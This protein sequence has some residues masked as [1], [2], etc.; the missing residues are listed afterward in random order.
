M[1]CLVNTS[2][3]LWGG[4]HKDPETKNGCERRQRFS[5][6]GQ[7][8][9]TLTP[10]T[11]TQSLRESPTGLER[12]NVVKYSGGACSD[13]NI[14]FFIGFSVV[15]FFVSAVSA[16]QLHVD[17]GECTIQLRFEKT[18]PAS[19]ANSD[20]SDS[21][22]QEEE[23]EDEDG[24]SCAT[25]SRRFEKTEPASLWCSCTQC[26]DA[27]LVSARKFR[28]CMEVDCARGKLTF[29]GSIEQISCITQHADYLALINSTILRQVA[30]LLQDRNGKMYCC[31]NGTS[32]NKYLPAWLGIN[33]FNA[34]YPPII[35]GFSLIICFWAETFHVVGLR[36]D[37]PRFLSKSSLAF[38]TFNVF[39]FLVFLAQF[40]TIEITDEQRKV[41]LSNIFTGIFVVLMFLMLTLF[42]IYGVE[43]YYKVRGAFTTTESSNVDITQAAM[44]R[45]GLF[46]QASLQLLTSLFLLGDIMGGKWKHKLPMEGR[47]ALEVVF[48]VFELGV[49][50]WFSCCLWN[51]KS[52]SQ[53]WILN[54]KRLLLH[55]T[56]EET[57]HLFGR[58]HHYHHSYDAIETDAD[59]D[60]PHR[61]CWIC[62][63]SDRTDAGPMILPCNC[64]GDVAAV[65]H[66]C[67][68]RWL[69]ETIVN[70]PN[71]WL[72]SRWLLGFNMLLV[73]RRARLATMSIIGDPVTG[74]QLPGESHTTAEAVDITTA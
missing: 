6:P 30:P 67:L 70:G 53:L 29:D 13:T 49:A 8:V 21:N 66:D 23:D 57:S 14:G 34:Y 10:P 60:A 63:D 46:S 41:Y 19:L 5:L 38:I 1:E 11:R 42:L 35:S 2:S 36:L 12:K 7:F 31:R 32:E 50:L 68:K 16:T 58:S 28:C 39:L 52:P 69:L 65:H 24:L 47:N 43:L 48:R 25:L 9:V 74:S 62:Y 71:L 72:N 33:L 61:D 26:S 3:R 18:E 45:F 20:E 51:W 44:S 17:Q 37:K 59:I 54:P 40:I 64:K 27:M 56:E 15:F 22:L 4:R 55:E 73:Y